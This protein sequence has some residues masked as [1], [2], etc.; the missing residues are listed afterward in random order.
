M[1]KGAKLSQDLSVTKCYF[2][3]SILD[4]KCNAHSFLQSKKAVILMLM[5][6][7]CLLYGHKCFVPNG[8]N[9][10]FFSGWRTVQSFRGWTHPSLANL[11]GQLHAQERLEG[12]HRRAHCASL[13]AL[14]VHYLVLTSYD[15]VGMYSTHYLSKGISRVWHRHEGWRLSHARHWE[16]IRHA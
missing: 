16:T 3:C 4:S 9:S 11:E 5:Q 10:H 6:V 15:K 12:G 8:R 14:H 7:C 1:C 13:G 2:E